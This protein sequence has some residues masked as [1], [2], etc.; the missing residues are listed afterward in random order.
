[1]VT[2]TFEK[3]IKVGAHHYQHKLFQGLYVKSGCRKSSKM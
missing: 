3:F 2:N 1:M